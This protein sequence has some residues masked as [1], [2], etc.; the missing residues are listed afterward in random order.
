MLVETLPERVQHQVPD[1][2]SE[3]EAVAELIAGLPESQREVIVMLK[4]M[5]MSLEEVAQGNLLQRGSG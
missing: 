2:G 5:G 1:T 4:V 3:Q